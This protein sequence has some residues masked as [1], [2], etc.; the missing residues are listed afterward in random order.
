MKQT[1]LSL[2]LFSALHAGAQN[3]IIARVTGFEN[4]D[5]VCR[6]CLYTN[7]S[8]LNKE[9]PYQ[10]VEAKVNNKT[11][12]VEFTNVPDGEYAIIVLHDANNNHKMDKNFLGI[13][14]EG[15]GASRNKLPFAAAPGYDDNKF[16]VNNSST[17]TITIRLR[18]L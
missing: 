18:N 13:P 7:A 10:C 1:I 4:S 9:T 11:S 6:A 3:K 16:A 8:A 15:Y 14:K 5:G 12:Q 2:L 17:V